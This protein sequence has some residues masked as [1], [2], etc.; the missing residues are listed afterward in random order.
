VVSIISLN[1]KKYS[2]NQI[3]FSCTRSKNKLCIKIIS[4]L[5]LNLDNSVRCIQNFSQYWMVKNENKSSTVY[6]LLLWNINYNHT[7]HICFSLYLTNYKGCT[8]IQ[9]NDFLSKE[10]RLKVT[11]NNFTS[12]MSSADISQVM[13]P[14]VIYNLTNKS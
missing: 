7:I 9:E 8:I 3:M 14:S 12:K 2:N 6:T 11:L 4:F 10:N 13:F 1:T 5:F